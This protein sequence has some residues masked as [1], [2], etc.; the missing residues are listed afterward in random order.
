MI[1]IVLLYPGQSVC[2]SDDLSLFCCF[3]IFIAFGLN[4][5]IIARI[6]DERDVKMY[7]SRF[8]LI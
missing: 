1:Y 7:L 8:Y 6:K 2:L 5:E 4:S 3:D